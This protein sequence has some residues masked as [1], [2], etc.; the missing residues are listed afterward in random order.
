MLTNENSWLDIN[1]CSFVGI[2]SFNLFL[3]FPW[4]FKSTFQSYLHE[5]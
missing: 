1:L 2:R 3:V 5:R 4:L